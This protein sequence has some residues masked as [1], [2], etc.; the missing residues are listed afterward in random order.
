MRLRLRELSVF[1]GIAVSTSAGAVEVNVVGLFP[2]KVVVQIDGGPL[3]T[4]SIGQR[5]AEG[6]VLVS[7]EPDGATFEVDG[8]RVALGLSHARMRPGEGAASVKVAAD[9]RGHF[10]TMGQ[11]NGI[12]V[13]FS[14]DTGA[15]FIA[16]HA[17][18]ARR[19]GLD[20]R[21]GRK[22]LMQT[23]AGV[24]PAYLITLDTV[25][26]GDITVNSVDAVVM[27]SEGPSVTL[28]GMSFLNRM[29]IRREGEIMT[30]TKRY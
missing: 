29:D 11:V 25:R 1:F 27:D 16:F 2:S 10:N 28:L 23:A 22:V 20:Y 14:V 8:Q 30:L 13:R 18:E 24:A 21:K 4:L 9:E 19:L 15:T 5:T 7:V 3:K 6:V 26:V 17:N 12:A